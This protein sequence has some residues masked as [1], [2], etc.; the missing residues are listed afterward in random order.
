MHKLIDLMLINNQKV[1]KNKFYKK[2]KRIKNNKN[3]L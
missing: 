1:N 3:Y 2:K